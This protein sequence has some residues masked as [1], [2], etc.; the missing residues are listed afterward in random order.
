VWA[1]PWLPQV[2]AF[3]RPFLFRGLLEH[4]G[5]QV[6]TLDSC[7]LRQSRVAA[8]THAHSD[9]WNRTTLAGVKRLNK[10]PMVPSL[11]NRSIPSSAGKVP[12]ARSSEVCVPQGGT[13][14]SVFR[15]LSVGLR[16]LGAGWAVAQKQ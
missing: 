4:R 9:A 6:Q 14:A 10:L 1:S 7:Q 15:E 2:V 3:P 16:R 8:A 5:V 13:P 11:G 12:S